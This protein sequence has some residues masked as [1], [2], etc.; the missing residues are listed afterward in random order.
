[1]LSAARVFTQLTRFD[2]ALIIY[3]A[4]FLP[5]VS[6]GHD[7]LYAAIRALPIAVIS[8]CGFTINNLYDIEKDR[9]NHPDRVLPRGEISPVIGGVIYF[10]L[11]AISLALVRI[12]A[13]EANAFLYL[14]LLLSVVNYNV[15]ITYFPYTKNIYVAAVGGISASILLTLT[16]GFGTHR[17]VILAVFFYLLG[18]EM[19]MDVLDEKADAMT[20][21]KIIGIKRSENIAYSM[22][23]IADALLLLQAT[24]AIPMT[25]VGCLVVSDAASLYLWKAR[26]SKALSLFVIRC[27]AVVGIYFLL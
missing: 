26:A 8:M 21:V 25:L 20:F 22:K 3:A 13:D 7:I 24:S 27:Q 1:M 11:L 10:G 16:G 5:L 17:Y 19:L 23:L 12:Y 18:K 9:E 15:A 4:V 6:A 14:L 2:A